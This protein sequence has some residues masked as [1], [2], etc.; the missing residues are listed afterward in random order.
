MKKAEAEYMSRVA[1][2]ECMLCK[3]QGYDGETPVELHHVR[4]GQGMGQRAPNWLVIPLCPGCHRGT[5]G[6][7]GDRMYLRNARVDEMDLLAMTIEALH[8]TR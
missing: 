6:I 8:D 7:H 4:E 5:N 1:Q 2:L 3:A